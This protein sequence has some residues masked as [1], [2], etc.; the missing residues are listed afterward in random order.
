MCGVR[1]LDQGTQLEECRAPPVAWFTDYRVN[2][3]RGWHV[4]R[5]RTHA[6]LL[7]TCAGSRS[8]P[9][10]ARLGSVQAAR[11][12]QQ[13]RRFPLFIFEMDTSTLRLSV[14]VLRVALTHRTHA[15]PRMAR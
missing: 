7:F 1:F 9:F 8:L 15:L 11:S 4:L 13:G 10:L 12:K 6:R 2:Q 3:L 5:R 14:S